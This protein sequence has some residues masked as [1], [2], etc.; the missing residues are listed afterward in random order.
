M[1]MH[2][3]L[4]FMLFLKTVGAVEKRKFQFENIYQTKM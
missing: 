2:Y 1:L 3:R 4:W